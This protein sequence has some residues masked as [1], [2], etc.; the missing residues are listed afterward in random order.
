MFR[1]RHAVI[2]ALLA[3]DLLMLAG[4]LALGLALDRGLFDPSSPTTAG[5]AFAAALPPLML[6]FFAF[7]RLYDSDTLFAGHSEYAAIVK[8]SATGGALLLIAAFLSDQLVSR[9]S[10]VLPVLF[11]APFVIGWRFMVRR[12]VFRLHEAGLFVRKWLIVGADQHAAAVALHL[13]APKSKGIR[14]VG[15]LDDYRPLGSRVTDGLSVLGDPRSAFKVAREQ[16]ASAIVIVPHAIGWESYRDLLEMAT[17]NEGIRI[18][19]APGLQH[20]VLMG[21]Q[22]TDSSFLPI[23]R[24]QPLRITGLNAVLKR[25]LDYVGSLL[26]LVFAGPVVA[27]GWLASRLGGGG[28]VLLRQAVIGRKKRPFTLLTIAAPSGPPPPGLLPGL[29]WACRNRISSGRLAKLPNV[30][31]VL[32]GHMSLVGPRALPEMER[33]E[34]DWMRNLLLVRPGLTGP[35][36]GSSGRDGLEEQTLKD[37]AYVRNYSLWLDL[38]L[39]FASF[40][41]MLAGERSVPASYTSVHI[42]GKSGSS[43]V[44]EIA[45][46]AT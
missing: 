29:A 46:R 40:K 28:P 3:G 4:A 36:A 17:E 12:L 27:L 39:L 8:G 45:G 22:M 1:A 6:V 42:H 38:R 34:E 30:L 7:N 14:V 16:G 25:S 15:F 26:L 24:L 41:R 2:A 10:L 5:V 35:A 37:V 19:V 9:G 20:L 43:V 21:A 31:N 11:S 23:V 44:T 32:G 13:N 33:L 18:K